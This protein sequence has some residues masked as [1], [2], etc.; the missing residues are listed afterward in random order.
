MRFRV[1]TFAILFFP[2]SAL[3][4]NN[5]IDYLDFSSQEAFKQ[6]SADLTGALAYKSLRPT[7][8]LG[9]TGFDIGVSASN[10]SLK[11]K[12]MSS[13]SSNS[14]NAINAFTFHAAKG[15]PLGIDIG[16]NYMTLPGSNL[17]S[18][19][20][21]VNWSFFDGSVIFPAMGF[22]GH[23]TQTNGINA[24][25]Y[26]SY[27]LDFAISKGFM[28]VTPFASVGRVQSEVKAIENNRVTG[29]NLQKVNT[30]QTKYAIGI[31][32][33]VLVMDITAAYNVIGDVPTYSLKAGYR[34]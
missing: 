28:N 19:G 17:S 4:G 8:S 3:A 31:N 11:Y 9:L 2:L 18:W 30:G 15:L 7:E 32:I 34:F 6:F 21:N 1:T 13:V 24:L 22:N 25:D 5:N 23:Y 10:S 29:V 14:G 12:Q 20:G 33:N 26:K 27:G 16:I